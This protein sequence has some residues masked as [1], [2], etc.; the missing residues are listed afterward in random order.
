[1][2]EPPEQQHARSEE[3]RASGDTEETKSQTQAFG[4]SG[5]LSTEQGAKMEDMTT[6][7]ASYVQPKGPGIRLRGSRME[8]LEKHL[9]QTIREK[10]ELQM[11]PAPCDPEYITTTHESFNVRGFVPLW[12][13][14]TLTH[15]Y[16][17]EDGITFWSENLQRVQGVTPSRAP[18]APFRKCCEFSRPIGERLDEPTPPSE[19]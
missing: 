5:L 4:H 13:R 11:K 10:I 14:L 3:Q 17:S 1:M 19:D 18:G 8:L 15:D 6:M 9:A 2:S 12:E 7:K 16:K